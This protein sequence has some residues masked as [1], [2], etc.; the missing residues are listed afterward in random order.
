MKFM[1]PELAVFVYVASDT[2]KSQDASS[3]II[4]VFSVLLSSKLKLIKPRPCLSTF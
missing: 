4:V 1:F 3:G 2:I